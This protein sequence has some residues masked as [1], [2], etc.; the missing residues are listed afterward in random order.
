MRR[1]LGERTG[2]K[3]ANSSA[4]KPAQKDMI[5]MSRVKVNTSSISPSP[6]LSSV[7]SVRTANLMGITSI[8]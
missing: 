5:S 1:F 7:S 6:S 2:S 8:L 4:S 3:T